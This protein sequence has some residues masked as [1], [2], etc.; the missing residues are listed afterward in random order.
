MANNAGKFQAALAWQGVDMDMDGV[1]CLVANL[2][3]RCA[4]D[5]YMCSSTLLRPLPPWHLPQLFLELICAAWLGAAGS[6]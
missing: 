2:I 6:S 1:E 3:Y 4:H 5:C